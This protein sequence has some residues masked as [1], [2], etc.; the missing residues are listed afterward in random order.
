MNNNIREERI[1]KAFGFASDTV[2]QLITLSIAVITVTTTFAKDVLGISSSNHKII[3]I[4]AWIYYLL[5][6]FFGIW[7]LMA[8]TGTLE[9]QNNINSNINFPINKLSTRGFNIQFPFLLQMS[10]FIVG[11]CLIIVLG[12]VSISPSSL[13]SP[14]PLISPSPSLFKP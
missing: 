4:A 2:K 6:V 5:S 13:P 11:T 12:V 9:P 1:K 14:K 10:Y 7:T 3:L 8:L